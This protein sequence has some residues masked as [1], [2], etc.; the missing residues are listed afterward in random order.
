MTLND[1]MID[2]EWIGNDVERKDYGLL[3]RNLPGGTDEILEK[4]LSG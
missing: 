4:T 1:K 3:F 2:G